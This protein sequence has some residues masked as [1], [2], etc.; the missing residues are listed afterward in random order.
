MLQKENHMHAFLQWNFC[1][2][3]VCLFDHEV[4]G[5]SSFEE[6]C[7]ICFAQLKQ[8]CVA[9]GMTLHMTGLT[10]TLLGYMK[11]SCYPVGTLL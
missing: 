6:H 9:N 5:A 11:S 4:I 10:R 7:E 3:Q 1:S 2:A 8:Y